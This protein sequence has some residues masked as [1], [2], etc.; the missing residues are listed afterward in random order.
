MHFKILSVQWRS[1][2]PGEIELTTAT[3]TA[4]KNNKR[5]SVCIFHAMYFTFRYININC[6]IWITV[7]HDGVY[8]WSP[9]KRWIHPL[10]CAEDYGLNICPLRWRHNDH[11]GV[12]N[13]QPRG[14]LLN[15]LFTHRSKKTSKFRVTGLCA[16]NSPGPVNSPHKGP[17]TRKML[18]LMTSSCSVMYTYTEN[19]NVFEYPRIKGSY[20]FRFTR[21]MNRFTAQG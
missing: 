8:I 19:K 20:L 16:G 9:Y 10:R 11:D 17:V 7:W 21:Y 5:W 18:P 3:T 15:R 13:H 6:L 2:W 14:C 12:S 1:F 4:T